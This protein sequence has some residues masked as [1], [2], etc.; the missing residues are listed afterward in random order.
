MIRQ[1]WK[2]TSTRPDEDVSGVL[3]AR[4]DQNWRV[5]VLWEGRL[6]EL[7]FTLGVSFDF[8]KREQIFRAVGAELQYSS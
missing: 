7:L 5:G 4:W 1:S 2:Q 8:Q 6:K 3:K